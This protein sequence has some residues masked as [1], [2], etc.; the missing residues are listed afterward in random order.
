[1]PLLGFELKI[2]GVWSDCSTNRVTTTDCFTFVPL[3]FVELI[4]D[5]LSWQHQQKSWVKSFFYQQQN[6]K[7]W[8]WRKKHQT[9]FWDMRGRVRVAENL[10]AVVRWSTSWIRNPE[11]M[12]SNPAALHDATIFSLWRIDLILGSGLIDVVLKDKWPDTS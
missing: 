12:D 5:H 8:R 6:L 11:S 2:S 7:K 4:F 1:M 3:A 10:E 9:H